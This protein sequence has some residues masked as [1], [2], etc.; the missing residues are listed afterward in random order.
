MILRK[1]RQ[2]EAKSRF[3]QHK[4]NEKALKVGINQ[5]KA[6]EAKEIRSKKETVK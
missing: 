3:K 5:N 6:E 2:D 1:K 4:N